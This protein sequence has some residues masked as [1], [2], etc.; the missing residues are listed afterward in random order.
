MGFFGISGAR[1][2]TEP[3]ATGCEVAGFVWFASLPMPPKMPPKQK[4]PP[5]LVLMARFALAFY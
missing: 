4:V 1:D 2:G 5:V 3:V